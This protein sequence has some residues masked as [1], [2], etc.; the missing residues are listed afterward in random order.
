MLG[1]NF[2]I[3][4][5][6]TD[7]A[8]LGIASNMTL[9][10]TLASS[11]HSKMQIITYPPPSILF[12]LR[13]EEGRSAYGEKQQELWL[14]ALINEHVHIFGGKKEKR[15]SS[16]DERRIAVE[17]KMM[18]CRYLLHLPFILENLLLSPVHRSLII[19]HHCRIMLLQFILL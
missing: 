3:D 10:S 12:S 11:N 19:P 4:N 8:A 2:N 13:T 15:P 16:F 9:M 18:R 14:S 7:T 1:M 6:D 17:K 5:D